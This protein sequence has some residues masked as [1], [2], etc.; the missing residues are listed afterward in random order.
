[1][2]N[3]STYTT[4]LYDLLLAEGLAGDYTIERGTRINFDPGRCPWV[5]IYPGTSTGAPRAM[6]GSQWMYKAELQIV[7]QTASFV[8]DGQDASDALEA[9]LKALDDAINT[10]LTLGITGCR[11]TEISREYRYVV[12][13]DDG[14]GELFMPQAITKLNIEVRSS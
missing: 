2:L 12:F 1:M 5:G 8:G 11:V 10:D 7:A 4:A 13:D 6:G 9:L 3:L 14:L